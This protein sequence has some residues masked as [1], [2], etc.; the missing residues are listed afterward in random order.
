[1]PVFVKDTIDELLQLETLDS[2]NAAIY[3]SLRIAAIF[4]GLAILK[5]V[6]LFLMRQTIIIMSRHIEYDL[7]NEIYE[8]YQTLDTDFFKKK[9]IGDLMNRI[10]EDVGLVRMYLGPGIMYTTNLIVLSSMIIFQMITISPSLSFYV[11]LPLPIMSYLIYRI[12]SKMNM[13]SR[14]TQETQSKLSSIA[15]ETFSG[16]KVMKSYL[17]GEYRIEKFSKASDEY[18]ENSMKLTLINAFFT[19]IMLFLIGTSTLIAV[20]I[21]GVMSHQN[22]ISLGGIVAFIFF[23]NNLTWPF[24]SIGWVTSIVQRAAASQS[25]INEFLETKSK[26]TNP[27]Q[28]SLDFDGSVM[29]KN[30]DYTYLNTNIQALK[31]VSFTLKKGMTLAIV[32]KTGSGKSTILELISRQ[33]DCC[34]GDILISDQSIKSINLVDY[35]KQLSIVP[36]DVFLFSDSIANNIS[37]GTSEVLSSEVIENYAKLAHVHQNIESFPDKYDTILGERGVNLSGGQK[38]RISIARAL[39]RE[40]KLLLLDDC[41]S[42]VDTETEEIILKNLHRNKAGRSTVIVSHRISTIRHA[43][44]ILYLEKGEIIEEGTHE[45]LLQKNGKYAELQKNQME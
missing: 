25:R 6:F 23:V 32:G 19:P 22:E 33:I 15:Q 28:E 43:D 44:Y 4:L 11:L 34:S 36:Q 40:P 30:V 13:A 21:G 39:T 37:F 12:S 35:R 31:N 16:I 18:K 29:F 10:S 42:A 2:F 27:S 14:Q 7:K 41:L 20:Y 38:Q 5:G 26:I 3:L 17:A 24:A 45:Q 9:S 8:H 1:M